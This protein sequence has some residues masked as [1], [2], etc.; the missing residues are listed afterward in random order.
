M[1]NSHA[2]GPNAT[3]EAI[4]NTA[5]VV[6]AL[7]KTSHLRPATKA[8]GKRRP[9][10]GLKVISPR[11][12]PDSRGRFSIKA[13]HSPHESCEKKAVVPERYV[14]KRRECETANKIAIGR[15]TIK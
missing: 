15:G 6:S 7:A 3:A 13:R 11:N 12:S 1:N 8:N 14:E 2:W 9:I 10:W 5:L 4:T